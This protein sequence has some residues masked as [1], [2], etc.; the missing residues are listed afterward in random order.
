MARPVLSHEAPESGAPRGRPG[1][2]ARAIFLS[3]ILAALPAAASGATNEED[4]A[5]VIVVVGAPGEEQYAKN[6]EQWSA[7]WEKASGQA[8]ARFVAVGQC[9]TNTVSDLE[10]LKQTL[11]KE[12]KDSSSELWLVL[13]GH[14]TFDGKEAKFNLRGPDF[15]AGELEDWLKPFRR[16]LAVINCA[17]SSGP[18]LS[19]LS[20]TNRVIVTATRSGNEQN[21]ARFG[22]FVAESITDPHADLD[23]DGQ[24][25]LLEAFLAASQRVAEFYNA[26]GRLATEHALLDDNGDRL[27]TP[28]GWFRGIRAVKKAAGG[29]ALDGLRAHQFHLVRSEQERKLSPETRARRDELEMGI[30]RLRESK[31]RLTE[32]DYYQQLEKML[33]EVAGLYDQTPAKP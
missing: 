28:A 22:Q 20:A 3:V 10:S 32:D 29:A 15:S 14:G 33:I 16:P 4:G 23:K 30:A 1:R 8:G 7:L 5:S 11:A 27:G 24:T 6:F 13:I 17:S 19:K 12:P 21:F 2:V 9:Q 26:E 25:S 31:S 18:F